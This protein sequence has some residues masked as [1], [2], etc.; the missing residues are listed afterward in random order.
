MKPKSVY[1][2]M[3]QIIN[4]TL[5]LMLIISVI[6][7]FASGKS[8]SDFHNLFE[9]Q[10]SFF[11]YENTLVSL[12]DM[13][14]SYFNGAQYSQEDFLSLSSELEEMADALPRYFPHA[15]F[16]DTK[17]LTQVYLQKV[18]QLID[19]FSSQTNFEL[20]P[21]FR[22][23]Q[24]VYEELLFQ[25]QT[26]GSVQKEILNQKVYQISHYWVIQIPVIIALLIITYAISSLEGR[27]M[28]KRIVQPL[29]CLTM[30]AEKISSGETEN[31]LQSSAAESLTAEFLSEDTAEE[32][33]L[34]TTAFQRMS[35][36]ICRQM[37]EL[38][39][40]IV[41]SE[42]LH[43]LEI[44][45]MQIKMSLAHAEMS[46]FQSL[47][48]PHFL[49]N[50]LSMLSSSALVEHAPKTYEYSLNI[51]QFLRS[52]LNLVGKVITIEEEINHIQYYINI[53][54]QRFRERITF[55]LVCDPSCYKAKIPA[56]ILQPIVENALV[57]GV[58]SYASGGW[59]KISIWAK[60]EQI[61]F[62][63]EDNGPGMSEEQITHL[64]EDFSKPSYLLPKKTGLYGVIYSLRYYFNQDVAFSIENMSPGLRV[65]FL[66]PKKMHLSESPFSSQ[67]CE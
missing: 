60:Q 5:F 61:M 3:A 49:F 48:N 53:Q 57:H 15:Q 43:A 32:I 20:L 47:I 38:K 19:S 46:Q 10:Q 25:Y 41:L 45:N 24:S 35:E 40:K 1:Q 54:K 2:K 22:D 66:F 7:L 55:T 23:I 52:S 65:R 16:V 50:C 12:Q 4:H 51:A 11:S 9:Q 18:T 14:Q 33:C 67:I 8:F 28:V 34:L 21:A 56:I 26:T 31:A 39:E 27:H 17:L 30:L 59:I 42:K 36:T 62:S 37:D 58:A 29:T 13:L 63:I 44:Q 6:S 64:T